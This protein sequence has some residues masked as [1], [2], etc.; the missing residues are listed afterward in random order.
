MPAAEGTATV[1]QV[2]QVGLHGCIVFEGTVFL[3]KSKSRH[4]CR[5]F[6]YFEAHPDQTQE[7]TWRAQWVFF[8]FTVMKCNE[9]KTKH[10]GNFE[11]FVRDP[12]EGAQFAV[13]GGLPLFSLFRCKVGPS[14]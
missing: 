1:R 4:L 14:A 13:Q 2:F 9:K 5:G 12:F 3:G 11:R 8:R 7:W 10:L 6:P